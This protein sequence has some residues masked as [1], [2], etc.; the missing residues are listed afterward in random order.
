MAETRTRPDATRLLAQARRLEEAARRV[1]DAVQLTERA[2]HLVGADA[3]RLAALAQEALALAGRWAPEDLLAPTRAGVD[4]ACTAMHART[5]FQDVVSQRLGAVTV[6]LHEVAA[7]LVRAAGADAPGPDAPGPG[8]DGA[9][10]PEDDED[11]ETFDGP[12]DPAPPAME[13]F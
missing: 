12:D 4:D 9:H 2:T 7:D 6:L 10:A 11:L 5:Q 13:L 8:A 3:A 1:D